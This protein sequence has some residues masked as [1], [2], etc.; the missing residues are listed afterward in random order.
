MAWNFSNT[1]PWFNTG[2]IGAN[3]V[4][5]PFRV[6]DFDRFAVQLVITGT[7]AG[8]ARFQASIDDINYVDIPDSKVTISGADVFLV[9]ITQ[10]AYKYI[11]IGFSYT[12]GVGVID[13]KINLIN[14]KR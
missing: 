8:V 1:S 3:Y 12:S 13:C 7:L 2:S 5:A 4:S 6:G 11:R 14:F 10:F 9:S